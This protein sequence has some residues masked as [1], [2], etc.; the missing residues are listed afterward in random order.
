MRGLASQGRTLLM[1]SHDDDFV[2]DHASRVVILSG[3]CVVEQGPARDVL[4]APQHP[5]TCELLQVERARR[6]V[7]SVTK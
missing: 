4:E 6:T 7:Q 3:G 2:R 5:A 1:T